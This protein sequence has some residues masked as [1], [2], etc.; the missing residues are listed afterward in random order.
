MKVEQ[1]MARKHETIPAFLASR[2]MQIKTTISYPGLA[3]LERLTR[4]F[5]RNGEQEEPSRVARGAHLKFMPKS[6]G[7]QVYPQASTGLWIRPFIK[8]S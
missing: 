5:S 2:K 6:S 1:Q 7:T 8:I 4:Q 3:K